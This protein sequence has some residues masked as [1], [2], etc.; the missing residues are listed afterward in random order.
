MGVMDS[1]Q[2]RPFENVGTSHGFSH[3]KSHMVLHWFKGDWVNEH[4]LNL[5]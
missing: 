4:K 1:S 2:T 5:V 3:A